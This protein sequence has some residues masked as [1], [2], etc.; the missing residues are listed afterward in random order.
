MSWMGN[1]LVR[2]GMTALINRL[3]DMKISRMNP[4]MRNAIWTR[5]FTPSPMTCLLDA[6][7]SNSPVMNGAATTVASRA[8]TVGTTRRRSP[9]T[10]MQY[11]PMH[12]PVNS[13]TMVNTLG[14]QS[15]GTEPIL[16]A[17]ANRNLPIMEIDQKRHIGHC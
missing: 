10:I 14:H 8:A 15:P 4:T 12:I 9:N 11:R 3:A 2:L 6:N 17:S 1:N 13:T 7:Y 16:K 5:R